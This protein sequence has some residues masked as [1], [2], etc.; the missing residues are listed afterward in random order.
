M[1]VVSPKQ[2]DD[3]MSP[4]YPIR[5]ADLANM[6]RKR[7]TINGRPM[8]SAVIKLN[9][10]KVDDWYDKVLMKIADSNGM[11][12]TGRVADCAR[13]FMEGLELVECQK[14]KKHFIRTTEEQAKYWIE[15]LNEYKIE[16]LYTIG[17]SVITRA[18]ACINGYMRDYFGDLRWEKVY[19]GTTDPFEWDIRANNEPHLMHGRPLPFGL[20]R[21][22]FNEIAEKVSVIQTCCIGPKNPRADVNTIIDNKEFIKEFKVKILKNEK[23][24][25]ATIMQL[26]NQKV[27]EWGRH[28][29]PHLGKDIKRGDALNYLLCYL[30]GLEIMQYRRYRDHLPVYTEENAR[31]WSKFLLDTDI[32]DLYKAGTTVVSLAW[33]SINEYIKSVFTELRWERIYKDF[34]AKEWAEK[35]K[36]TFDD[37]FPLG[38][39]EEDMTDMKT[40]VNVIMSYPMGP[41]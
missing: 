2:E 8:D 15:V 26:N 19:S 32:E 27:E 21:E 36:Q 18:W 17:P 30:E 37:P 28:I 23:E 35:N 7:L 31:F 10:E 3:P 25:N 33:A 5:I 6:F 38:L 12:Q 14:Y 40:K 34:P 29:L 13:F 22:T 20:S 4:N 11:I 39:T 1:K 24:M 41:R 9:N 16:D